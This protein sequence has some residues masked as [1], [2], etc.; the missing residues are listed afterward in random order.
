MGDKSRE[1]IDPIV[2]AVEDVAGFWL[3]RKTQLRFNQIYSSIQRGLSHD[4]HALPSEWSRKLSSYIV[5]T[6]TGLKAAYYHMEN[7]GCL[8]DRMLRAAHDH[9][10]DEFSLPPQGS[11]GHNTAKID[12]EYHAFVL[13]MQRTLEYFALAVQ[14]FFKVDKAGVGSRI[15]PLGRTIREAAPAYVRDRVRQRLDKARAIIPDF[16]AH[17][18]DSSRDTISHVKNIE[19]VYLHVLWNGT[20]WQI[21]LNGGEMSNR[22]SPEV[23]V[24][25]LLSS[26]LGDDLKS[27]EKLILGTY[28]DFGLLEYPRTAGQ[29]VNAELARI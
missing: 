22:I 18:V 5:E 27:A 8:E 14:A 16:I 1:A 13:A 17:D 25:P 6:E 19:P 20:A 23:A 24:Q 29:S 12:F 7:I 28:W 2:K 26:I 11:A 3:P 21:G 10:P 9:L 15:R 4:V